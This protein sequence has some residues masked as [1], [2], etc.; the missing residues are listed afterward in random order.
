[1]KV[2]NW[3]KQTVYKVVEVPL[4]SRPSLEGE[5]LRAAVSSLDQHPGYRYL[6]DK[7]KLQIGLLRRQLEALRFE[8]TDDIVF[9]QAGIFW[10]NFSQRERDS[11]LNS[12][13]AER[14]PS[15]EE[16]ELAAFREMDALLE[17][18]GIPDSSNE[19]QAQA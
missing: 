8:K 18:V 6:S 9:L 4:L 19:P 15:G 17:R 14:E 7:R 13:V 5:D 11:I 3:L 2:P 10:L 1:M 12:R 16:L